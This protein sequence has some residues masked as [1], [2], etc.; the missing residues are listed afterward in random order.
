MLEKKRIQKSIPDVPKPRGIKILYQCTLQSLKFCSV[1]SL[2]KE[3]G[4]FKDGDYGPPYFVTGAENYVF[5]VLHRYA[6][7]TWGL[8]W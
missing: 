3:V 8:F 7:N 6:L 4:S 2:V 1:A 5:S